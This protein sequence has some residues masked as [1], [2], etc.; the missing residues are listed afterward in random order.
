MSGL[1]AFGPLLLYVVMSSWFG[2]GI[3]SLTDQIS[4]FTKEV[5]AESTQEIEG[6]LC[7]FYF[8][9]VV[10]RMYCVYRSSH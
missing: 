10:K 5:I 2:G 9:K 4:T 6:S 7:G 1:Q 3:T 8:R